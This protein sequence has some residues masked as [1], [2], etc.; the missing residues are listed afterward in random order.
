MPF[1]GPPFSVLVSRVYLPTKEPAPALGFSWG[2]QPAVTGHGPAQQRACTSLRTPLPLQSSAPG[3]SPTHQLVSSLCTWLG[4][5]SHWPRGLPYLPGYLQLLAALQQ[6]GWIGP[7]GRTAKTALVV[8]GNELLG[9]IGHL[10]HKAT[11]L[12]SVDV[13]KLSNTQK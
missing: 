11:S 5:A 8:R 4:H 10:L 6:K 7:T 12:R 1:E 2:P 13:T 3:S 9:P